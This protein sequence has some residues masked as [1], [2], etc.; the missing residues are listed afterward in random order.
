ML[1]ISSARINHQLL[2]NSVRSHLTTEKN[3]CFSWSA[4]SNRDDNRQATCKA[5]VEANGTVIWDSGIV[6]TDS[7][8]LAYSGPAL[9]RGIP[10]H[11]NIVSTD[12]YGENAHCSDY[13]II[14]NIDW[15]ADWI[16][17]APG[18]ERTRARYFR[19][20]FTLSKQVKN[21]RLYACGIGYQQVYL[22]GRS[23][24]ENSDK[25]HPLDPAFTDYSKQA[26]YVLY[27]SLQD[28]LETENCIGIIVG[29]G[30]R[31]NDLMRD[32]SEK[33]GREASFRGDPM[34]TAMLVIDYEDGT[35]ETIAT[36]ETW[37][38]GQGPIVY[39]DLYN[40]TTFDARLDE[41]LWATSQWSGVA[42]HAVVAYNV[43]GYGELV[44]MQLPPIEANEEYAPI[45]QW[46]LNGNFYFDFGQNLAGVIRLRLPNGLAAGQKITL[47]HSEELDENG[48]LYTLTLRAA[49]AT[50]TYIASGNEKA[51]DVFQAPFTFHG[52]RYACISGLELPPPAG[53]VIAVAMRNNFDKSSFFTC[54]NPLLN[55]LYRCCIATERAN[56]HSMLTDCPQRNERMGWLNDATVRFEAFPYAFESNTI[57]R[58]I[59]QDVL[60]DQASDGAIG[61]TT[62]FHV[63]GNMPADPVCSS[64]LIAGLEAY[65]HD[66]DID[67][68]RHAF[69]GFKAWTDCLLSHS[70][71]L[72]VNYSHWG[73]WAG[74]AYACNPENGAR[75]AVTPGEFMSTGFLFFNCQTISRMAEW[76]GKYDT[77]KEYA[78]KA[79]DVKEAM[80]T[81]WYNPETNLFATGSMACIVFPLWLGIYPKEKATAAAKQLHDELV[82]ADYK[83]TTGNL[84]TRYLFEVLTQYGF[85]DEAY[86]L[87]TRDVYPSFGFM[88]QQEATTI[89]ERFE[90]KKDGG[91]NSHNHPM[92]ASVY[93][94]FYAFL[95]GIKVTSPSCRTVTVKPYFPARLQSVQCGFETT[96]GTL[97]VRW[98]R[99]Y[100]ALYLHVTVPFGMTATV[101]FDGHSA[102]CGSGFHVFEAID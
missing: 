32:A 23:L 60:N 82:A 17:S 18:M 40:G 22:N 99:R 4:R 14:S 5:S 42:L 44:P 20:T 37:T 41:P 67:V 100:G 97:S 61:D 13:F 55:Q 12:I 27:P 29:L 76:L 73:D 21:A 1:E 102:V 54:G 86:E 59:I 83:F 62:P 96:L 90:L 19:K 50:D 52:F 11:F 92:Y 25:G 69:D 77:A 7:Q 31:D 85:V 2:T 65:L 98:F 36:D 91:M 57:F 28:R 88:L 35:S 93:H 45:S 56:S 68:I 79:K 81:K 63:F 87:A 70:E 16:A 66:G 74:P 46:Q 89:W 53:S 30:W 43:G 10:L 80:L 48:E 47:S 58:K 3:L 26:Q 38:C 6:V 49:K 95:A 33:R 39:N 64:F 9:P 94:W 72:I 71:N 51:G 101:E 75:S 15:Q 24:D 34:L 78:D 8:T 84:C